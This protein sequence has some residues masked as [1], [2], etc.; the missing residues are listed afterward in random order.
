MNPFAG[1]TAN[2]RNKIIAALVLGFVAI[3]AMY[4][5]F[6]SSL[7]SGSKTV[8]GP[9][10][11]TPPPKSSTA[12]TDQRAFNK[13]PSQSEQNLGYSTT[14]IDY[15]PGDYATSPPGR[16]IFAFQLPPPCFPNCPTPIPPPKV[17]PAPTPQPPPPMRLKYVT[18]Q[19]IYAGSASFRLEA[20]GEMFDP[21]AHLYFNQSELPTQFVSDQKLVANV[22]A[23]MIAAEGPKQVI[24][25]TPD[26]KKYSDQMI[27]NVMAPP[28]PQ[29]VYSGAKLT[30]RGNNN[31]GYFL[32]Q[33]KQTPTVARLNDVVG[34]RFR[35]ISISRDES[36]FEDVNLGFK[37]RL[38]LN[39]PPPG[40]ASTSPNNQ[41]PGGQNYRR[42]FPSDPNVYQQYQ[43]GGNIPGIPPGMQRVNPPNQRP[44]PKKD[45]EDDDDG[46]G[47][48]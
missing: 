2:E 16:N 19:T 37:Y 40:T 12:S 14:A 11:A 6:G 46:G 5:A 41:F 13:M 34:G 1:K 31:T 30:A 7:F 18:P 35:L 17:T 9:A 10:S 33:G 43:D 4:L 38:K 3:V 39:D 47:G 29:F 15:R 48:N 25:Q 26:G 28:R 45:D 22:P 24:A 23:S 44:T 20:S 21:S 32:E 8:A 42:G 36:V 27:I